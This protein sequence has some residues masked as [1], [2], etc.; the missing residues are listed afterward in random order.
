MGDP[1][2]V[3]IYTFDAGAL[4]RLEK[5]SLSFAF[6]GSAEPESEP[7]HWTLRLTG[8]VYLGAAGW[9]SLY[10]ARAAPA[11]PGVELTGALTLKRG[12]RELGRAMVIGRA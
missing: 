4:D 10:W 6:R 2:A 5:V 12:A 1:K 3:L 8:L 11:A 7:R 9:G